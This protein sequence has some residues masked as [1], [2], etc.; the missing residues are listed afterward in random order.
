MESGADEADEAAGLARQEAEAEL[1]AQEAEL[2]EEEGA[3]ERDR[4]DDQDQPLPIPRNSNP[5]ARR[6]SPLMMFR[7]SNRKAGLSIRA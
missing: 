4:L 7:P 1:A 3:V 2:A 6:R 5:I